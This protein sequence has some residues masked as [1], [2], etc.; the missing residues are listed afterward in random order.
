MPN[1]QS[2]TRWTGLSSKE[3]DSLRIYCREKN[4]RMPADPNMR[5]RM[6]YEKILKKTVPPSILAATTSRISPSVS[7]AA[8][9][10]AEQLGL[11]LNLVEGNGPNGKIVVNDI[12]KHL[13]DR[14]D[15]LK[16][17]LGKLRSKDTHDEEGE[18][19]VFQEEAE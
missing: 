14:F 10:L 4:V 15:I 19:D 8:K 17:E 16:S 1:I 5:V 13:S 3:A 9:T 12:R 11:D 6:V 2:D 7:P 18:D